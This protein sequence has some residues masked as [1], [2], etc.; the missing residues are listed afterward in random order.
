MKQEVWGGGG[1]VHFT[2]FFPLET[3]KCCKSYGIPQKCQ[4]CNLSAEVCVIGRTFT[5]HNVKA[6]PSKRSCVIIHCVLQEGRA[7]KK[8]RGKGKSSSSA[9]KALS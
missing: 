7:I 4:H 6:E 8:A 1:E 5:K 2:T 9:P 3:K